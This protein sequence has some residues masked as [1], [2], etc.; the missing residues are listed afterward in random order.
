[1]NR[2]RLRSPRS[3]SNIFTAREHFPKQ[4]YIYILHHRPSTRYLEDEHYSSYYGRRLNSRKIRVFP[5]EEYHTH[6]FIFVEAHTG[7]RIW[8]DRFN[9][10]Q[11][12]QYPF[13]AELKQQQPQ[14]RTLQQLA[15]FALATND[16]SHANN[17]LKL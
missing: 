10:V 17:L 4:Y 14:A 3:V 9:Y 1:M 13:L 8:S 12:Y 6:D 16:V 15:F 5:T 2:I 7:H 11:R